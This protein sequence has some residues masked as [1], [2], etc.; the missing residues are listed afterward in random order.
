[1]AKKK[2][3]FSLTLIFN[4][5]F[6]GQAM[7]RMLAFKHGFFVCFFFLPNKS[8]TALFITQKGSRFI[9]VCSVNYDFSNF[10]IISTF[11]NRL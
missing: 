9:N 4:S 1:M 6:L 3:V 7:L 10:F 11:H 8:A 5:H 2:P